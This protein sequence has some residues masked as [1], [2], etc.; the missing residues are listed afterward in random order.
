[1]GVAWENTRNLV[2][3]NEK[4][5]HLV[6]TTVYKH[7]KKACEYTDGKISELKAYT[8]ARCNDL[9]VQVNSIVNEISSINRRLR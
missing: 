8:D 4:G 9:Q 1:M 5:G 2:F 3:T 6:H 7:F